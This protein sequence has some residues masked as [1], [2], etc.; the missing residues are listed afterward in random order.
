MANLYNRDNYYNP[1][2]IVGQDGLADAQVRLLDKKKVQYRV[3]N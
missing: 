1:H 2:N 3:N